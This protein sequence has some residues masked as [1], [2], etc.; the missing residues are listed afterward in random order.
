MT[1]SAHPPFAPGQP[2]PV[3]PTFPLQWR[4]PA[5]AR[6]LWI[7]DRMHYP[8]PLPPLYASAGEGLIAPPFNKAAARY[9]L[10]LRLS[11]LCVN[12]YL[13]LSFT[14]EG[15]PPDFVLKAMN[16]LSQIAPGVVNK[17]MSKAAADMAKKYMAEL[18]PVLARLGEHWT[19]EWWPELKSHLAYWEN[20]DLR[21][22]TTQGLIAHL[23]ESLKRLARTWEIHW[24]IVLPSFL[25]ISL[26]EELYRDLFGREDTL[27][28]YR[29][30]QG[31]DNKFL[32]A[33]RA[34][35][36]LSR[37]ALTM[38]R[39]RGVLASRAAA[40]AIPALVGSPEGDILLSELRR[41]LN[42]YGQRGSRGDGLCDVSWI[43][44][45][46]PVVKSLK[47]YMTQPDRDLE[48]ELKAQAA[49]REQ[50]VAQARERLKGYPPPTVDRFETLLKAA[51][52]AA[53]LHEEHNYWIDQRSQY[54]LRRIILEIGRRFANVGAIAKPD[55]AFYLTLDELRETV[56]ALLNHDRRALVQ[57]RQAEI[58]RFGTVTPPPFIGAMP[59][60]KPPDEPFGRS[61]GKVFG[62]PPLP[63]NHRAA[64]PGLLRGN[65][66][67]PGV[68]RGR[69]RIIRSLAEADQ[70]KP[71]EVLVAESTLPPWT[72]LF[73]TTCAV[74][75]EVGGVLSHA[76]VVAREY[77]IP[78]VVGTD[79]AT[80]T[81]HD[82][83]LLEVDGDAGTV[84]VVVEEVDI[85]ETEHELALV[86]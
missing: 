62:G 76:A 23:D 57:E 26:F 68:A 67:S 22:A 60:M 61:L 45:P 36:Q 54:Q 81:F 59:L 72:P 17:L 34:L 20:F 11:A 8:D 42:E 75:T 73:A 52:T 63:T 12:T 79:Y 18:E 40:D 24:L 21:G 56:G 14:P 82:G 48:A 53:F 70:L 47:D 77:R 50:W 27:G 37:Q 66:A 28:A 15:A 30:L 13:Y 19:G 38:P 58:E 31:F 49:E 46:T 44:D 9:V 7:Q 74:V 16:G 2:L 1:R 43:E 35:W 33:D 78:A 6:Q 32:E 39:A 64:E 41:Y 85:E 55:D 86:G 65:A 5:Q 71:G 51:Q 3:S 29:L 83:Q 84:R 25:A 4:R 69:A 80:S 10:P